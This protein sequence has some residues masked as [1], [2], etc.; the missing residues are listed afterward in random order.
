MLN[1][2]HLPAR[3]NLANVAAT[4]KQKPPERGPPL[5]KSIY[6]ADDKFKITRSF[7]TVDEEDKPEQ[8]A[9]TISSEA[10]NADSYKMIQ[11]DSVQVHF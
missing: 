8:G 2:L 7:A 10:L 1:P 11:V 5:V 4:F 9:L 3:G 6:N